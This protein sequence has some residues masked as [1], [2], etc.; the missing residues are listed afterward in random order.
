[1]WLIETLHA[2]RPLRCFATS[3]CSDVLN[4][5]SPFMLMCL[6]SPPVFL[7]AMNG[8]VKFEDAF[9]Q[10]LQLIKPTVTMMKEMDVKN[11]AILSPHVDT[12]VAKLHEKRVDVFLVSGGMKA[13]SVPS[14]S[15]HSRRIRFPFEFPEFFMVFMN[16]DR[17]LW[18]LTLTDTHA[19]PRLTR[20]HPCS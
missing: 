14:A 17:C 15:S 19:H 10:R 12:L 2:F 7:S 5:H 6:G 4:N 1:M 13:V 18:T 20:P 11:P 8:G 3:P 9:H 16:P